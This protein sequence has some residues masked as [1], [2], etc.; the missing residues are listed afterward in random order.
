LVVSTRGEKTKRRTKEER[1]KR[2]REK[3]KAPVGQREITKKR[4]YETSK[5]TKLC[6]VRQRN[7]GGNRRK[8]SA[9]KKRGCAKESRL[10][11]SFTGTCL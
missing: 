3:K 8:G 2:E 1:T 4:D 11:P 9:K 5:A 6:C 10:Q 7:R